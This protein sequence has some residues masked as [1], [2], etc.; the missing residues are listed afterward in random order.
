MIYK[1]EWRKKLKNKI[2]IPTVIIAL[3]VSAIVLFFGKFFY[4]TTNDLQY[5]SI[6]VEPVDSQIMADGIITSQNEATLHFQ[7]GGKL[8]WL[9]LKEGDQVKQGQLIAQLDTYLLQEQLTAVL[10]TYR[11]TRDTFDQTKESQNKNVFQNQ[12]KTT[13]NTTGSGIG[14]QD[15]TDYS[16]DVAK[17]IIDQNQ[18]NLD[19]S[20]IAVETANYAL[21]MSS[22]VSP[23]NGIITHEDVTSAGVN[24]SPTTSFVISDQS[25]LIFKANVSEN[26]IDFVN[27]ES[28]AIIHLGNG[29][30]LSGTIVKIYP[31]KITLPNGDRVYQ[32]DIASDELKT[33][34]K[35]GQTGS[36]LIQ[37]NTK[38]DVMIVPNWM[39][40]GNTHIW[41][42]KNGKASLRRIKSGK[43]HGANIEIL[44]GLYPDDKII[45]NP[46]NIAKT[47]Y[48]VL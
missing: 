46:E 10:N 4:K 22:L 32:V 16:N 35:L 20:V 15:Q 47:K 27:Q 42:L 7:T 18:A 43:T 34:T 17:R 48:Q 19:N 24:I 45:I 38:S 3:F 39:V 11:S 28:A 36:V 30:T 5:E 9:P 1:K 21:Q 25:D 37:S 6:T 8:A 33:N 31:Q 26:D 13:L 44:E 40:L 12:T 23:I 2:L 29:R 41:V 14:G